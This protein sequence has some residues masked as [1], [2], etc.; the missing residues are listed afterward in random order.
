L[1]LLVLAVLAAVAIMALVLL[2]LLAVIVAGIHADDRQTGRGAHPASK[3]QNLAH[4]VLG[5][6]GPACSGQPSH[7][8]TRS[9]H[10]GGR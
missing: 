10:R 7:P 2:V 9:A 8:S 4:R 3:C 1:H 5:G 6:A